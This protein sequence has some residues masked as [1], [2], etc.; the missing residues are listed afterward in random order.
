I[1]KVAQAGRSS[2]SNQQIHALTS[3]NGFSN[4]FLYYRIFKDSKKIKLQAGTQAVPQLNKS[5][6]SKWGSWFPELG[7][8][9]KI[10][11]FL[12]SVDAWLDNLRQQKTALET[13]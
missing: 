13:Y 12:G 10:A 5:D 6:F 1:G 8:Q 9:Q 11:D 4:N 2:I 7:E 3:K